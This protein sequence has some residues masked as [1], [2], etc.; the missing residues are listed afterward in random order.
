MRIGKRK[1]SP[2][3]IGKA[4]LHQIVT[5]SAKLLLLGLLCAIGLTG[6]IVAPTTTEVA[7]ASRG[8][9]RDAQTHLAVGG[10]IVTARRAGFQTAT[11]T[12]DNGSFRLSPLRQWH[13]LVYI[14][15][16]GFYPTPWWCEHSKARYE[17]S[18]QARGYQP[19]T[20][21]VTP[22]DTDFKF[23]RLPDEIYLNLDRVSK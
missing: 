17:I 4:L 9:V 6:C 8:V 22:A 19:K 5:S 16:P 14:G 12:D 13:Y 11:Q 15:S 18:V 1:K 10:A 2:S 23:V 20:W 3:I 21:S 7:P